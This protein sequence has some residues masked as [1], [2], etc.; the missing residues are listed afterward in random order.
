MPR[1]FYFGLITVYLAITV[2]MAFFS[3]SGFHYHEVFSHGDRGKPLLA[4]TFDDGPDSETTPKVLRILRKYNVRAAFFIIGKKISGNEDLLRCIVDAGHL[5]GNHSW[6][7]SVLWDFY[8]SGRLADDIT[9]NINETEKITGLRMK[10]FRPP[11]GVINP[12]VAKAITNT[13]VKVVGWSF[14][15]FDTTAGSP[16]SL[17]SKTISKTRPGDIL[18]F[19]D[20]SK[21][22]A[23]I[24]EKIIVSLQER[25][26]GFIPLDEL[27]KLQ[28]Y[29]NV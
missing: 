29:E 2:S 24:L 22:T 13:K 28:A 20:S 1:V 5:I 3:S 27:L 23:G 4:L 17:L 12:M 6:S 15:S 21:L 19:H 18:L 7:H 10:L 26:F 14:R 25:G 8:P 11:Y 9:R 16:E